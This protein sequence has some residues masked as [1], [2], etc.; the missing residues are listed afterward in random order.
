MSWDLIRIYW[1]NAAMPF[2]L[3]LMPLVAFT[4]EWQANAAHKSSVQVQTFEMATVPSLADFEE[5]PS[6]S[7][8]VPWGSI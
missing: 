6:N 1:P 2:A 8:A 3:A 7:V 5:S 4:D